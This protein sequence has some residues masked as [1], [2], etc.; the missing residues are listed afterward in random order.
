MI[1]EDKEDVMRRLMSWFGTLMGTLLLI[2]SAVAGEEKVPLDK[3][4][5]PVMEAV[6]GRFKGADVTGAS[7]E[8]E[9][10]KLVYEVT[11]KHKG[12]N[13]DVSLTPEGRMFLVE[14]EIAAK[15]LPKPVAKTLADKYPKA[16]YKIV[17]E[18]FKIEEKKEKLAYYEVL[19]MTA[20]QKAREVEVTAEGKIVKEEKKDS[21]QDKN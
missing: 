15:D 1:G 5:K 14:K 3:V 4:P 11:I 20:A 2:L 19:L 17:E 16:T 13:I 9:D 21:D 7:K 6:K 12:Q 8:T 18:I 10:G